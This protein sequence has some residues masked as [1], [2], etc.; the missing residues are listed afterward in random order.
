M[1][2]RCKP[3]IKLLFLSNGH[4][5]D[6]I[7]LEI[8]KQL[9]LSDLELAALPLVGEGHAYTKLG[10]PA[11]AP[12]QTMPSGGF[13][14][15]DG[16]QLWKD[17]QQGLL[18][19]SLAQLRAVRQW[20]RTGGVILA[21]GDVVPL[22]FAW[23]SGANYAFI[24]TAKSEYHLRH[25]AGWHPQTSWLERW[26]G[27]YYPWERRLMRDRRCRA[28]FPRDSLTAKV[29]QQQG[30]GAFDLGNPMMDGIATEVVRFK[31][32]R[33]TV[34]LLPGSRPPEAYQN[35]RQ[36]VTAVENIRTTLTEPAVFLAAIAPSLDLNHF[37]Q[38]LPEVWHSQPLDSVDSPINPAQALAF[39]HHNATLLLTSSA[40]ADCLRSADVA[41]SM[42]GT[43][44]EQFVGLGKAVITFPGAGP[45]FTPAFAEAYTRLLG[46]SFILVE[47]PDQVAAAMRSLFNDPQR[48]QL[49]AENGRQ[50]M[51][52][53]G[54]AARIVR[55]LQSRLF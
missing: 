48:Q 11:I 18:G 40:Y 6:V 14:Y 53:P 22:L 42:A 51:G 9:Q 13:I 43:A 24:G 21:V 20:Q 47:R 29:L 3:G 45:Q 8:A 34:L 19:L 5:E 10:V 17:V 49:V 12:V 2:Q 46:P 4:G 52:S 15:M 33:L 32:Q 27:V 1:K 28:V 31:N 25:E 39:T 50:R 36:I 30:I 54:A 41:I 23:L 26:S 16:F 55:C 37:A 44:T 35:W 38:L 7:A